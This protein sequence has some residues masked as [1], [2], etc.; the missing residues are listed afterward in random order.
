MIDELLFIFVGLFIFLYI[1]FY[2]LND[3]FIY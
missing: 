2:L 3:L 1:Y